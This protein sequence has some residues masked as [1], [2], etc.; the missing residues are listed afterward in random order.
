MDIELKRLVNEQ[1][2]EPVQFAEWVSPIVVVWKSDCETVRICGDFKQNIN[3]TSKLDRYPIAKVQ[4][5]FVRLTWVRYFT[6]LTSRY[7][8]MINQINLLLSILIRVISLY[9]ASLWYRLCTRDFS[10]GNNRHLSKGYRRSGGIL[11]QY[12]GNRS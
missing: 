4:D 8:T 5:L 6:K 11:G 7:H 9:K 10:E 12:T 3:P 2:L 1:T